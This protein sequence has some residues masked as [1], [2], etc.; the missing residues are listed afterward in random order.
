MKFDFMGLIW[1]NKN[2]ISAFG[3]RYGI[4]IRDTNFYR[5]VITGNSW[6][7]R[8]RLLQIGDK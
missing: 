5:I 8:D 1:G 4:I 2:P 7:E 6:N 3:G